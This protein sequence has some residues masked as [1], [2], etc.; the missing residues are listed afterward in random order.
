[1]NL[2]ITP[3]ES[4]AALPCEMQ[5][6]SYDGRYIVSL[7]TLVALK[8]WVVLCGTGGCEKSRLCCVATWMSDKQRHSKRSKW[9]PSA[10]IHANRFFTT[11]QPQG[12]RGSTTGRAL[13]LRS[14]GRGFKSCSRQRC[15]RTLGKLFTPASVTKQYNL[16]PAKGW[17]CSAAGEVTAS[18]VESNGSLPLGGWL[19][20]TCRL[21]A[22][23]PG[24]APGPTLGI[25]YGKP[26]PLS[27][28]NRIVHHDL[29]K[30]SPCLDKPLPQLA[31]LRVLGIHAAA[32]SP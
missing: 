27:L 11:D 16:V 22:Y 30:F 3:E 29:L 13:D 2:P 1:M 32:S 24:S 10:W 21:T 18:L 6:H 12:W 20:V 4:H 14:I 31:V 19:T 26:L 7:E 25:E 8:R 17:W 15:V 28:T 5:T 23:T 9:P